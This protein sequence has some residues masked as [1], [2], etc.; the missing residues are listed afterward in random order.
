MRDISNSREHYLD[1]FGSNASRRASPN[2]LKA[3]TMIKIKRP[4][5]TRLAG[6]TESQFW[7]LEM[8]RPRSGAGSITP[9]FRNDSAASAVMVAGMP[10]ENVTRIGAHRF[11]R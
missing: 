8:T 10:S 11:G 9:M 2:R 6:S 7:L 4:G 3:S 1:D 5:I